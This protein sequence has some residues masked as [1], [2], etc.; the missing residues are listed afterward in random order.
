[1]SFQWATR[2]GA[3]RHLRLGSVVTRPTRVISMQNQLRR[4]CL[5]AKSRLTKPRVGPLSMIVSQQSH[6]FA[7]STKSSGKRGRKPKKEL[8][9]RQKAAKA[10]RDRRAKVKE[11]K[12]AALEPPKKL[13]TTGWQIGMATLVP[14]L[15]SRFANPKETM[16]GVVNMMKSMT[17]DELQVRP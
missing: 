13:P 6:Y 3:L 12:A 10:K 8:T 14:E 7:T 17:P 1:M 16:K 4:V 11:L 2:A 5:A 15:K 9:E